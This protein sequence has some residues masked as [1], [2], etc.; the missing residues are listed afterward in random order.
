MKRP[1]KFIE[2]RNEKNWSKSKREER[3]K[4]GRRRKVILLA[5]VVRYLVKV[6]GESRFE[7]RKLSEKAKSRKFSELKYFFLSLFPSFSLAHLSVAFH[8]Y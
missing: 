7:V 2:Y 5:P 3:E 1:I 4:L 6:L 8:S